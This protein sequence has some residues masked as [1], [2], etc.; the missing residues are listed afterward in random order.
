MA[1]IIKPKDKK[2]NIITDEAVIDNIIDKFNIK[3]YDLDGNEIKEY[4][5]FEYIKNKNH[6]EYV[7]YN[8][9]AKTN[10]VKAYYIDEEIMLNNNLI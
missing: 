10:V 4:I 6:I 3:I 5:S 8:K 2:G 7:I 9:K 1:F